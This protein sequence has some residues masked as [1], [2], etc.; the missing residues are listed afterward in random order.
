ML[1]TQNA[2]IV[3][4][5]CVVLKK[6]TSGVNIVKITFAKKRVYKLKK[7]LKMVYLLILELDVTGV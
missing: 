5:F 2:D 3:V 1:F 7:L 6:T 4:R